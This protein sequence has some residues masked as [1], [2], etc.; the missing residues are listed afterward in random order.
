MRMGVRHPGG[1]LVTSV[2]P[3]VSSATTPGMKVRDQL[4]SIA[5]IV[6]A[7]EPIGFHG[8]AELEAWRART[9]RAYLALVDSMAPG[10]GDPLPPD[11]P[12]SVR[13]GV[14]PDVAAGGIPGMTVRH[15]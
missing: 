10:H 13:P 11:V 1:W 4:D 8:G 3:D 5:W 9:H 2:W 15:Q 12:P 6:E 7:M 14:W